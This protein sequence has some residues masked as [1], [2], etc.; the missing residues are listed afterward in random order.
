[1]GE[2]DFY[3]LLISPL[4]PLAIAALLLSA[5][6]R[7]AF[8]R[9]GAYRFVWHRPLFDLAVFIIILGALVAVT[10]HWIIS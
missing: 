5:L 1:M 3:G 2:L 8:T 4:L 6:L 10:S 9:A 7:R